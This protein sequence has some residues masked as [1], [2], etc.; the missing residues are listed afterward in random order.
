VA[1]T[2]KHFPGLG[3]AP[4]FANTD[5]GP[6]TIEVR[7]PALRAVDQ[8]PYRPA[9]GAGLQL[10]MVSWA[11]Y[12]ALDDRPAGLSPVVVGR[13]LRE[14]LGFGGVTITDSLGVAGLRGYGPVEDRALLATSAG[15]DLLLCAGGNVSH[16]TRAVKALSRAL[17]RDGLERA[18]F[19][20]SVRRV[21]ALRSALGETLPDSAGD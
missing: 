15:M 17:E 14:R 2:A 1:A 16:G 8:S 18:A 6:A 9:I 4:S 20:A 3:A 7:L 19:L 13:E 12:P 5:H 10:V 11:V 21:Q